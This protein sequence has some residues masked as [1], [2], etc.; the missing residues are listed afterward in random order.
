MM[1]YY[2]LIK[3]NDVLIHATIWTL[4]T[5]LWLSEGNQALKV[6]Y[7]MIPFIRNIQNR[8]IHKTGGELVVAR[9]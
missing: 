6:T 9:S 1:D 3:R 5:L 4:K 2:S 7:Y 8:E